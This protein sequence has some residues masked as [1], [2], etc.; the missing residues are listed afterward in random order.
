MRKL[1]PP[2]SGAHNLLLQLAVA[3]GTFYQICERAEI[4]IESDRAER[5]QREIIN[6]LIECGHAHLVGV[7]YFI[8]TAARAAIAPAQYVGQAAGPVYRGAI[9]HTTVR[10]ARRAPGAHA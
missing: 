3:P 4:D 2:R 8:T 1:P 7:V 5:I 6:S 9:G 10:I